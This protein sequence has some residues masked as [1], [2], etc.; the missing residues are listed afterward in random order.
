MCLEALFTLSNANNKLHCLASVVFAEALFVDLEEDLPKLLSVGTRVL[1]FIGAKR[2]FG[3][4][5]ASDWLRKPTAS[6]RMKPIID[7]SR[8]ETGVPAGKGNYAT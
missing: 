5:P 1:R 8:P 7:K 3:Q 6:P 4:S 2:H